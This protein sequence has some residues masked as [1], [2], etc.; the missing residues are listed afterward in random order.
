MFNRDFLF[1]S[2]DILKLKMNRD[3]NALCKALYNKD[4]LIYSDACDALKELN[5]LKSV[6]PLIKCLLDKKLNIYIRY[7]VADILGNLK[8]DRAVDPLISCLDSDK[9]GYHYA[10]ALGTIGSKKAV[11]PL[12]KKMENPN[13]ILR[14]D[15]TEALGNLKD[16]EALSILIKELLNDTYDYEG[17]KFSDIHNIINRIEAAKALGKINS[18]ISIPSL[19]FVLND[20]CVELRIA[21][22][23]SL[24]KIGSEEIIPNLLDALKIQFENRIRSEVIGTVMARYHNEVLWSSAAVGEYYIRDIN[25]LRDAIIEALDAFN[26]RP[27]N[28]EADQ[29]NYAL[30]LFAKDNFEGCLSSGII[31]QKILL[32]AAHIKTSFPGI[33]LEKS[34]YGRDERIRKFLREKHIL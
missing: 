25:R 3:V 10:K 30:Y 34:C 28:S 32:Q 24:R 8:S 14:S 17:E 1:R 6:D 27:D 29:F 15:Y 19:L 26:W 11:L 7:N 2:P 22:V 21:A 13:L 33:T 18:K 23:E 5:D 9:E 31:G 20:D 4:E 12:I 16:P